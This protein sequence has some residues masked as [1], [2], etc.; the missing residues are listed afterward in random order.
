MIIGL[1]L[2]VLQAA[3]MCPRTA[4]GIP[5]QGDPAC[6]RDVRKTETT[7]QYVARLEAEL[8]RARTKLRLERAAAKVNALMKRKKR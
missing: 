4:E 1:L 7:E 6:E 5:C 3:V 8:E 2:V